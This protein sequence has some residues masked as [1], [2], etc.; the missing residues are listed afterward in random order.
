MSLIKSVKT[1][2][3]SAPIEHPF[4]SSRG[5]LYKTRG[6]CLVEIETRD[7]VVGWVNATAP[8]RLRKPSSTRNSV[9]T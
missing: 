4:Q 2:V 6:T 7:G 3:V 1:H 9:P 5:W 8:P